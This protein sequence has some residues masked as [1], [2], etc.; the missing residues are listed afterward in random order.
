MKKIVTLA[1]VAALATLAACSSSE[2]PAP[3]ATETAA[4]E[5]VPELNEDGSVQTESAEAAEGQAAV[6]ATAPK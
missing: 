1:A 3:E 6:D 2:A 5:A 4:N